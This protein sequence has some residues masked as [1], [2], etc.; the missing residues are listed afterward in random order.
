M[1]IFSAIASAI[2]AV[3]L[4]FLT[5][6]GI[7]I[8]LVLGLI[9]ILVSSFVIRRNIRK[10]GTTFEQNGTR[11]VF[12]SN[13]PGTPRPNTEEDNTYEL[14]PDDYTISEA[15]ASPEQSGQAEENKK[16]TEQTSGSRN[17]A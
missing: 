3:A 9:L 1:W 8:A 16:L 15:P 13:I 7:G 17:N 6:I 4:F 12:Y 11:F 2:A 10:H 5:T 14:S